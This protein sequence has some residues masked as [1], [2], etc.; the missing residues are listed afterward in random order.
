MIDE[1]ENRGLATRPNG[2]THDDDTPGFREEDPSPSTA[3]SAEPATTMATSQPGSRGGFAGRVAIQR[4]MEQLK[5][6]IRTLEGKRL[7]D[8]DKIKA[9]DDLKAERD[10][11]EQIMRKL[12]EKLHSSQQEMSE[13]R[14]KYKEATDRASQ[15]DSKEGE[16]DSE[17]EGALLDK[18]MAEERAECLDAELKALQVKHEEVELEA[19][20]LR[21][22]NIE[23][24]SVMSPEDKA[25][26]GWLSLEREK[27]RYKEALVAL[28]EMSQQSESDLRSQ[29]KDL[30]R[31]LHDLEGVSVKCKDFSE[32]LARSEAT[33]KYLMEQLEVAE[34]HEEVN[35]NLELEKDGHIQEIKELKNQLQ[36]VQE[37]VAVNDEL[38]RYHIETQKELQEEL[39]MRQTLLNEKEVES[40]KQS[41]TID[42]QHYTLTKFRDLVSDL[43]DEIDELR[44]S[45]NISESEASDLNH[46]SR[47]LMNLNLEL[48]NS[49]SKSQT[50]AI[51]IELDRL[52][53]EES[54]HHL[55]IVQMFVQDSFAQDNNAILALMCFKRIKSKVGIASSV[56]RDHSKVGQSV[57]REDQF[58]SFEVL[59]Q[60]TWI[61]TCCGR[62]ISF[63]STCSVQDFAKY[64]NAMYQLEPVERAMNVWIDV[65][66]H[67][68]VFDKDAAGELSGMIALLSDLAEKLI[69]SSLESKAF[70]L[71]ARSINAENLLDITTAELTLLANLVRSHV[72]DEQQNEEFLH[73]VK[74]LDQLT[75]KIRT[76]RS[77]TSKVT[78]E[79][80]SHSSD[81]LA[82][83][84]PSWDVFLQVENAAKELAHLV[85][86]IGEDVLLQAS[87]VERREPLTF[88]EILVIVTNSAKTFLQPVSPAR[89]DQD[90][91]L[92]CLGTVVQ[93]LHK[94]VDQMQYTAV[95]LS[96]IA[97]VEKRSA[98]WIVR[99]KEVR[100]RK[101]VHRDTEEELRKLKM[102]V[103]DQVLA[104]N[105]KN[106]QL[107]E[108]MIKVELFESRTKDSQQYTATIQK[109]EVELQ[110]LR[111][112]KKEADAALEKMRNDHAVLA[113]QHENETAEL[114][115]L[116]KARIASDQ[117]LR[118]GDVVARDETAVLELTAEINYLRQEI[119]NLQSAVRYF[120]AES[121]RLKAPS[122]SKS[123][124]PSW[125]DPSTLGRRE[126]GKK[127][128]LAAAES[129]D[130]FD[131]LLEIASSV[132]PVVLKGRDAKSNTTW[133]ATKSTWRYHVLK[134]REELEKWS[135]WK[136]DLLKRARIAARDKGIRKPVAGGIDLP[137]TVKMIQSDEPATPTRQSNGVRIV[138]SPP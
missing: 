23:L 100:G 118:L 17:I 74:K 46:K 10:R 66:R 104:L 64:E 132:E 41:K 22:Q 111:S 101:N 109:L 125:L 9:V 29:V 99:S 113:E 52:R 37:E 115:A 54:S 80:Q 135:E 42:E 14:E 51:D 49:A 134:Q 33:N 27:D 59:E 43:Q 126:P 79:I 21:D 11:Y 136:D 72:N 24:G 116:R 40:S 107:E 68:E 57:L 97:E 105:G 81:G 4:E 6:K 30:E 8:R 62:F 120:K 34:S 45:R 28:H 82:L 131:G 86:K 128:S 121:Q 117:G 36:A 137:P 1:D 15:L 88:V 31:E 13:L 103:Q 32:K 26:A 77:V 47:A 112:A 110:S 25:N 93:Q 67:D 3:E 130:V 55:S 102:Q 63:M 129:K 35:L 2:G 5:A 78:K 16:R 69:T 39:D 71:A 73:A 60:L 61:S 76:M 83:T 50:K 106:R 19:E 85:R 44:V 98:P 89:I 108:H 94:N 70:E 96:N 123:A 133:R 90:D 119:S 114:H 12:Q 75:S 38:E 124:L 91:G 48:Q 18:E 127:A 92:S 138:G 122:S 84:E 20:M 65:L 7:E 87:A 58:G 56:L 53:A 95:D